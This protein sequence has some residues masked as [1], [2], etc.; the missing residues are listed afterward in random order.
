MR[1]YEV[2]DEVRFGIV[3]ERSGDNLSLSVGEGEHRIEW[4]IQGRD[5]L[6]RRVKSATEM[7]EAK[8]GWSAEEAEAF[9]REKHRMTHFHFA[10]WHGETVVAVDGWDDPR[11]ERVALVLVRP[12]AKVRYTDNCASARLTSRASRVAY[13][14]PTLT[15]KPGAVGVVVLE[16]RSGCGGH[17]LL[18]EMCPGAT[19][20][21]EYQDTVR[22]LKWSGS[23]MTLGGRVPRSVPRLRLAA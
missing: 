1:C 16:E 21:I 9:V 4:P 7:I 10:T 19:L 15:N 5:V 13:R 22:Y 17:H 14:H 8:T 20:R 23:E 2:T 3:Y 18:A 12:A 6:E 11:D